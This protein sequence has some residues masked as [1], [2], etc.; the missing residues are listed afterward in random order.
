[1][2]MSYFFIGVF[3]SNHHSMPRESNQK[4]LG[5]NLLPWDVQRTE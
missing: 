1:M 2:R 3:W 4:L 5:S